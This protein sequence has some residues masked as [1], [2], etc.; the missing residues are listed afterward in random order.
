MK[1]QLKIQLS[2]GVCLMLKTSSFGYS[3]ERAANKCNIFWQLLCTTFRVLAVHHHKLL[4]K[5]K[6]KK[7]LDRQT[8][9]IYLFDCHLSFIF[10]CLISF[11]KKVKENQGYALPSPS[12]QITFLA[13]FLEQSFKR[14]KNSSCCFFFFFFF[15]FFF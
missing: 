7:T 12:A 8:E 3:K 13:C 9:S 1:T 10:C 5:D 4:F 6:R 2:G 11:V 14:K 15:F